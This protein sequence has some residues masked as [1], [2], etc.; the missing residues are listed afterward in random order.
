HPA[1]LIGVEILEVE[2]LAVGAVREDD[3]V[4]VRSGGPED[5]GPQHEA[6]ID[7]DEDV[8]V[9][10]QNEPASRTEVNPLRASAPPEIEDEIERP[11][12]AVRRVPDLHH[13]VAAEDGIALV[14]G[15]S[16][17]VELGGEHRTV[18]RLDLDVEVARAPGVDARHD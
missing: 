11:R 14:P 4:L 6:V 15:L 10:L 12:L 18:G 7:L 16:G 17:K 3:R 9:D 13:Q 5:V 1:P 8:P 2:P